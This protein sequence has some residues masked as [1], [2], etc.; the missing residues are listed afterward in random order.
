MVEDKCG[1]CGGDGSTCGMR[2]KI[3][4]KK[5]RRQTTEL[6]PWIPIISA[7]VILVCLG[8]LFFAIYINDKTR[9]KRKR[10][11][12]TNMKADLTEKLL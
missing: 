2:Q 7:S 4:R 6:R 5:F 3:L 9:K 10:K 11:K 1:V 8:F 12:A